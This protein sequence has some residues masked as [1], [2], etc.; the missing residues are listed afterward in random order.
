MVDGMPGYYYLYTFNEAETGAE[1]A[2]AQYFLFRGRNMYT[3]VFQA[4]PPRASSRLS[5]VFDQMAESFQTVPD[6]G[7]A[8]ETTTPAG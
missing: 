2:H 8:P 6:T 1:G 4:L 3:L 7:S 5:R